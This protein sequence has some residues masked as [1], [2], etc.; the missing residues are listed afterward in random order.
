M[1]ARVKM[2]VSGVFQALLAVVLIDH[3]VIAHGRNLRGSGEKSR[4]MQTCYTCGAGNPC[5]SGNTQYYHAHCDSNTYVQCDEWG[6]CFEILCPANLEWNQAYVTCCNPATGCAG[7]AQNPVIDANG[8]ESD[9]ANGER[10]TDASGE[11]DNKE[12]GAGSLGSNESGEINNSRE[13]NISASGAGSSDT[14]GSGTAGASG[15]A[16]GTDTNESGSTN[17]SG[18][19]S[20]GAG[21]VVSSGSSGAGESD[22]SGEGDNGANGA[23]SIDASGGESGAGDTDING[24]GY[25]DANAVGSTDASGGGSGT[26]DIGENGSGSTGLNGTENTETSETGDDGA[27]DITIDSSRP[28]QCGDKPTY[29]PEIDPWPPLVEADYNCNRNDEC[30]S[31]CCG[32][33]YGYYTACIPK[34]SSSGSGLTN[35]CPI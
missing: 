22:A 13:G 25:N 29:Y 9:N 11:G 8:I 26:E 30:M 24:G 10:D 14:N 19:G 4:G 27:N 31:C 6:S 34:S 15:E 17:A 5:E 35:V 1:S 32:N 16:G 2:N 12:V 21:G 7:E 28:M 23:G 18:S 33:W 20:N 3:N